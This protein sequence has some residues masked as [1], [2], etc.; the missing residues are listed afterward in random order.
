MTFDLAAVLPTLMPRVINWAERTEQH[1]LSV[2]TALDIHGQALAHSVGVCRPELIRIHVTDELPIPDDAELRMVA[3]QTDLLGAGMRALTIGYGVSVR[4]S[5]AASAKVLSHEF[6]HVYQYE[7][8]GS[9][10]QFM[11]VYFAEV[12]RYGYHNAPLEID[13]RAHEVGNS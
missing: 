5:Y 4:R 3:F 7:M 1:V 2:G 12:A 9:I 11:P 10:R 8:L 13:A 6:R